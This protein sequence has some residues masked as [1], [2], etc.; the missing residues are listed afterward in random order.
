MRIAEIT[1]YKEGGVYTHVAELVKQLRIPSVIITGNTKQSG[2]QQDEG[3]LFYHIPCIFSFWEI[4]FINP[5][6]SFSKIKQEIKKQ[7]IDLIHLHGPLF[8]FCGGLLRKL[9]MPKVITTHYILNFKGN[10]FLGFI[11]RHIIRLVTKSMA[12]QVDKIICVNEEYL[13]IFKSWGIDPKKIVYIPNG[14]D[15]EKFSPGKSDVKKKLNCKNLVIYWGRLGYQKNIQLLIKAFDRCTTLDTKLVI[16]GKGPDL[17]KLKQIAQANPNI[18]FPG[19]LSDD[20]LLAYA[21]GADVAVF[22]SRGESWGLVV[23]EA[24]ACELPVISS[25]VGKASEFLGTDRGILIDI[26]TEEK[27]AKHIDY[28]LIKKDIAKEMGKRA[29]QYI[30]ENY[31]WNEVAKKT[32]KIYTTLVKSKI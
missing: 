30:V 16:I 29:R 28:L 4:Y 12:H 20:Q 18:I 8:T 13:P 14:V 31:S 22:P 26:E 32:K 1:T 9:D 3:L 2:Y 5:P 10:K 17:P 7:N 21:R 11:Y 19:Y 24:M 27:L 15:T 25:N 6:G 23:A